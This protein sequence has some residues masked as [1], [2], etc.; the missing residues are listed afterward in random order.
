MRCP[1]PSQKFRQI[2]HTRLLGNRQRSGQSAGVAA[3]L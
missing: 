1:V 3:H 2:R